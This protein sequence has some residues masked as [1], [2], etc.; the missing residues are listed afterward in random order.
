MYIVAEANTKCRRLVSYDQLVPM[1]AES[2]MA[3][4]VA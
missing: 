3:K 4:A 2:A 1:S